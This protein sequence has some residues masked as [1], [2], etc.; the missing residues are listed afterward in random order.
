VGVMGRKGAEA[1]VRVDIEH[2]R[3]R[4]PPLD[5]P[6]GPQAGRAQQAHRDSH[7]HGHGQHAARA[8]TTAL[9]ARLEGAD[10]SR[11]MEGRGSVSA[12]PLVKSQAQASGRLLLTSWVA[13]PVGALRKLSI[14]TLAPPSPQGSVLSR[15]HPPLGIR[16]RGLAYRHRHRHAKDIQREAGLASNG[17]LRGV[18]SMMLLEA[19]FAGGSGP[20]KLGWCRHQE[21]GRAVQG[22]GPHTSG[23]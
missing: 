23:R 10:A 19:A 6:H 5:D 2:R 14:F 8:R 4:L 9:C 17:P 11:H 3:L 7:G 12:V 16:G 22:T 13:C 1:R 15:S 18:R 21:G 20:V